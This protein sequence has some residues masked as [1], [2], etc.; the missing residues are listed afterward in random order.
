[1][2]TSWSPRIGM[3]SCFY[4]GSVRHTRLH[5]RYHDFRYRLFMVYLDLAEL[6][7]LFNDWR[8]ASRE[9]WNWAS[10]SEKHYLPDKTVPLDA[11]VRRLVEQQFAVYPRGRVFLMTHLSYWGLCFNPASF[12]FVFDEDMRRI[13]YLLVEVTNTPWGERHTYV[14]E[15][16][17]GETLREFFA[18]KLHV[19]PFL[20]MDYQYEIQVA[21][22]GERLLI[23]MNN[24]Q[25]STKHFSA[26]LNLQALPWTAEQGNRLLRRYPWMTAKV[27]AAIHWQALKLWCKGIAVVPHPKKNRQG[28]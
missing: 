6:E 9:A 26:S 15:N 20:T 3:N 16:Q 24:Y 18:K 7:V 21:T 17:R 4:E 8:F 28:E 14:L 11:A 19:S 27:L 12:Y 23:H 1:M 2:R 13:Q 5:P 22:P 25:Q 10:F